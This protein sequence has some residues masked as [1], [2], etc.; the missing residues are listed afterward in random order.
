VPKTGNWKAAER[1]AARAIAGS[2]V[3]R[4]TNWGKKEADGISP[5]YVVES[6]YGAQCNPVG[7]I[8]HV[9]ED[10]EDEKKRGL[11]ESKRM[12]LIGKTHG[13]SIITN[14]F[15]QADSYKKGVPS[16][17]FLKPKGM[18]GGL[19]LMREDDFFG[20]CYE[21]GLELV[22]SFAN[23]RPEAQT[24]TW[25]VHGFLRWEKRGKPLPGEAEQYVPG[26]FDLLSRLRVQVMPGQPFWNRMTAPLLYLVAGAEHYTCLHMR[27]HLELMRRAGHDVDS[28]GVGKVGEQ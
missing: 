22:D 17:V 15:K 4:G 25:L 7:W 6:K 1:Q 23:K 14:A 13:L 18:R 16:V 12:S 26:A 20:L 9:L 10:L 5:K 2:R 8:R 27:D 24:F 21:A 11:L 19:V 28:P 3:S